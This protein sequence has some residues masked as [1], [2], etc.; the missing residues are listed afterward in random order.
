MPET[1]LS[2]LQLSARYGVHRTTPWRW[3]NDDETFPK[4]VKLS[5]GCTRWKLSELETWEAN[6]ASSVA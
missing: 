5:P 1:Y 4:P 6:K 2:D 3:Y